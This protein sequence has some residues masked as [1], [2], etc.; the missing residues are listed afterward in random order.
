MKKVFKQS[1]ICILSV[2]LSVTMFPVYAFAEGG[3]DPADTAEVMEA[4]FPDEFYSEEEPLD[5]DELFTLYAESVLYGDAENEA[6]LLRGR[7]IV[8]EGLN[9]I[10]YSKLKEEVALV[11][12]G[13]NNS[14]AFELSLADLGLAGKT[15]TAKDLG[16]D[17]IVANGA[18]SQE[19]VR[20]L[21]ASLGVD[22]N[23]IMGALLAD[24]PYELYWYD[25]TVG[26]TMSG[27][28]IGAS[29]S[30]SE[31]VMTL[32]SGYIFS[33][34]VAQGYSAGEYLVDT[35]GIERVHHAVDTAASIVN[36]TSS[37]NDYNKLYAYKDAICSRVSYNY[38]A[39]YDDSTP[40]GDPWQLISVFDDDTDTNIVCEGYSKAFQYLCDRTAFDGDINCISVSG[41]MGGGTGAGAHMWN[42]VTMEDG[43]NYLVDVTN[44]DDGTIG[45]P[46]QLF[47]AGYDSGSKD[48]GYVFNAGGT[49]I[50][51]TYGNDTLNLYDSELEIAGSDYEYHEWSEW[52]EVTPA[53]CTEGGLEK[54]TCSLCGEEQ[55][56]VTEA[57]GHDYVVAADTAVDPTCSEA[58]HE[59]D[60][61][62]TR[63]GD[64]IYGTEIAP[65]GHELTK[66]DAKEA[67]ETEEGNIEYWVCETCG[68]Y[69]A[70]SEGLTEISA[71]S[72]VVPMVVPPA[73][74]SWT[75]VDGV[76]TV[77]GEGEMEDFE[78]ASKSP[79]YSQKANITKIVVSEGLTHI[80]NRAFYQCSNV[81]EVDI[82]S[83][84]ES[85]GEWA[86]YGNALLV[87]VKIPASVI[88]L[89]NSSF[90]ACTSLEKVTFE[91]D[92]PSLGTYVFNGASESLTIHCYENTSGWDGE[93]W[94]GLN[95]SVDHNFGEVTIVKEPT[96]TERGER[97]A[98]CLICGKI[99]TEYIPALGHD[100]VDGYCTRCG[101]REIVSSGDCGA[102]NYTYVM[103]SNVHY[104]FYGDGELVISGAGE[105]HDWESSSYRRVPWYGLP[106]KSIVIESGVTY[107]GSYAF[108]DCSSLT[109]ITIPESVRIIGYRAFY[110]CSSLTNITIPD[111]VTSIGDSAFFDCS[112]LT[113]IRIPEGITSIESYTFYNC[114]SL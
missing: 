68:K 93:E 65:L 50:S 59:D 12:N 5:N 40:Y 30:G 75:L 110:N 73:E 16:V 94:S 23:V 80:G 26:V 2:M 98:V 19:A 21:Q 69:F 37:E 114:S 57:L 44:C 82:A 43:R 24:C 83:S 35:S 62:C 6:P 84:V 34:A 27:P 74:I 87:E 77:S 85:I 60:Q 100:Y 97:Q 67:T 20:A 46:D 101:E 78:T 7:N 11:A 14:T 8:P 66:V 10:I 39:A 89:S 96:C 1:L 54:R 102:S 4:E 17:A 70:D 64:T 105:M 99:I 47:L 88:V 51:Y 109:S 113:S 92:A 15:W 71:E 52:I 58:G 81:T 108:Y 104:I 79:W 33:L 91:G 106:V 9:G 111:S 61:V 38:D 53:T 103:G 36:N 56:R 25:K 49:G 72:V 22:L 107:I 76:L 28:R 13:T 55:T 42:I 45:A 41:Y 3:A 48:A 18:I 95:V 31:Y 112:S 90:R 32:N 86:F 63:C 29:Y